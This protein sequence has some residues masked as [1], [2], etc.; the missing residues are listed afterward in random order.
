MKNILLFII[1][2]TF[3]PQ[4]NAHPIEEFQGL[5]SGKCELSNGEIFRMELTIGPRYKNSHLAFTIRYLLTQKNDLRQYA[6]IVNDKLPEQVFLDEGNGAIFEERWENNKLYGLLRN[7]EIRMHSLFN[8]KSKSHLEVMM[9][10]FA[11]SPNR[12]FGP[13]SQPLE[14]YAPRSLQSCVLKK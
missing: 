1:I 3:A 9:S 2:L 7:G 5:W 14:D 8:F 11:L 6:M 4:I 10:V 13:N 12:I